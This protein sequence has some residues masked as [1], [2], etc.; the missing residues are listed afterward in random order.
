MGLVP[1]KRGSG[2]IQALPPCEDTEG[3]SAVNQ[4]ES[5]QQKI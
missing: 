3:A 4:E 1:C 2:E 5:P